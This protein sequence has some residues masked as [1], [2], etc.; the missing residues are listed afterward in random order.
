MKTSINLFI[1][2][3]VLAVMITP[4]FV[5][6]ANLR[7]HLDTSLF[8]F[9]RN[10]YDFS[11]ENT[12]EELNITTFGLGDD[13]GIS[14][15]EEL[16]PKLGL[17]R[18]GVGF[19]IADHFTIGASLG[20]GASKMKWEFKSEY[21]SYSDGNED[22]LSLFGFEVMPYVS[23]KFG[24][25]KVQPFVIASFGYRGGLFKYD[26]SGDA[27]LR[28]M[29][30]T[31]AL[32]GGGGIH[33]F[34]TDSFSFDGSA[35]LGGAFGKYIEKEIYEDEEEKEKFPYRNIKVLVLLG[36]SGWI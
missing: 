26:M 19:V 6:A 16:V 31:F 4:G 21:D 20:F 18:L 36:F 7:L 27:S 9:A 2:P 25:G 11:E 8:H 3:V 5:L 1:A 15:D 34:I 30:H 35:Q 32:S 17:F 12:E 14:L 22:D 23:Y 13:S 24:D 28:Y 33:F 29:I 10:H